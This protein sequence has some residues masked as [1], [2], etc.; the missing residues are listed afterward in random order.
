MCKKSELFMNS[1]KIIKNKVVG[2]H[3]KDKFVLECKNNI[4]E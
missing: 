2:V 1:N 4:F 3:L